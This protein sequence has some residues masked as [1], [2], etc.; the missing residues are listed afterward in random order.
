MKTSTKIFIAA[1]LFLVAAILGFDYLLKKEFDTDRYK[2]VYSYY[3]SLPYKNFDVLNINASHAANVKLVQGPFS[4]K[5]V[6]D[7]MTYV[8]V[9]QSGTNLQI[10]VNVAVERYYNNNAYT[11]LVS[12]P[13]LKSVNANAFVFV[14]GQKVIDTT[15]NEGW[16]SRQVLIEGF[17]QDS[18]RITQSY[19][20][21]VVLAN[22]N[23]RLVNVAVG[24]S[25]LSGS[26]LGVLKN[27]RFENANLHILN[28]SKLI[29]HQAAIRHLNYTMADSTQL[30]INGAAKN[31][32]KQ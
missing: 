27:N 23:I 1:L 6:P 32:L 19:G 3:K 8:K 16:N 28:R 17:K 30:L 13:N 21:Y 9:K 26:I 24:E 29:L 11:L 2:D 15:T 31:T 10:D 18:L 4:V 20:S 22:N 12:C 7:A 14:N 25:P 5:I